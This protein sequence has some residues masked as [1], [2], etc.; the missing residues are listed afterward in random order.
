M[1]AS[2]GPAARGP[3]PGAS[4]GAPSNPP[5]VSS[6]HVALPPL[7][8]A[9]VRASI[10][11]L[12][13]ILE[14][15]TALAALESDHEELQGRFRALQSRVGVLEEELASAYVN[16]APFV[17]HCQRAYDILLCQWQASQLECAEMRSALSQRLDNSGKIKDVQKSLDLEK[18][19]R[20]EETQWFHD[21]IAD[22]EAKLVSREPQ[23]A[24]AQ[25]R[26]QVE[27]QDAKVVELQDQQGR[28]T[29]RFQRQLDCAHE[30][31]DRVRD[32]AADAEEQLQQAT[33]ELHQCTQD[34]DR[35]AT[36]LRPHQTPVVAA[37]TSIARLERRVNDL[38][39]DRAL[40]D[41]LQLDNATMSA[42]LSS[43]Q[44]RCSDSETARSHAVA[45]CDA[46][47]GRIASLMNFAQS[48]TPQSRSAS[49]ER[50]PRPSSSNTR[51]RGRSRQGSRS[52]PTR[53]RTRR[54]SPSK[55][56]SPA[57]SRA[58]S[59]SSLRLA[60][61][62]VS[63]R[64]SPQRS[65]RGSS[66]SSRLRGGGRGR[67]RQRGDNE[68][69]S[70]EN[71]TDDSLLKALSQSRATERRRRQSSDD[72]SDC[73][74]PT[75]PIELGTPDSSGESPG[76]LADDAEAT[77]GHNA[78][79][80]TVAQDI[81]DG[82]SSCE[83]HVDT[84]DLAG[85]TTDSARSGVTSE[86]RRRTPDGALLT[87]E[88]LSAL[89]AT[90]IP[91]NECFPGYADRRDFAEV[92]VAPWPLPVILQLSVRELEIERLFHEFSNPPFWIFPADERTPPLRSWCPD[93]ITESNVR[94]LYDSTP[95]T[96]L[97]ALVTPVSFVLVGWFDTMA[98]Q[99][100]LFESDYQQALWEAT[101]AFPISSRLGR[102]N[103]SFAELAG[104]RKQRR[105]RLG[106]RW[107][108]FLRY[109]LRGII[110]GHCDLDIFLD[111]FFLHFPHAGAKRTW[112]PGL[113]HS[114]APRD[115]LMALR[116]IDIAE[117]WRNQFR[118]CIQNHPAAQVARLADKFALA[119]HAAAE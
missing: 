85:H 79:K 81:D 88:A 45:E 62:S 69:S 83:E 84:D 87:P 118:G 19:M 58:R 76:N 51:K 11:H 23:A 96:V 12:T 112:Y 61:R 113:G 114:P 116:A 119:D 89:P 7:D 80:M 82:S 53:G 39:V 57:S 40:V 1:A 108:S 70:S 86:F 110:A 65:P 109:M 72:P 64:S 93:L 25:L 101:H 44:R 8:R 59:P 77:T 28:G 115:L 92:G 73:G 29:R 90:T 18:Q 10:S 49:P 43:A 14:H 52:L 67:A 20:A 94:A 42:E 27:I 24:S 117:P 26:H 60:Q 13:G 16:A 99:Y 98:R 4:S 103:P 50:L 17:A 21:Q 91:R 104:G 38:Q 41:R 74:S 30:E 78:G 9:A 33:A 111:S 35:I 31:R 34:R 105:S 37:R 36:S 102:E 32:R 71:D 3:M 66:E 106:A 107:K 56:P 54:R 2:V 46:I 75:H 95:W 47:R 68:S 22:F 63:R 100:S 6:I 97:D 55:S 48:S 5:S 15:V